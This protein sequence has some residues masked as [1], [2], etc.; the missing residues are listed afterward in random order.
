MQSFTLR[1]ANG[2]MS[3]KISKLQELQEA[4][5]RNTQEIVDSMVEMYKIKIDQVTKETY[6][7][8]PKA[9]TNN[10]KRAIKY[11]EESGNPKGCGT[12][13]GWTRAR[14]LANR[15]ALSRNT[16]ARMSSFNRHRQNKDV[17]YEEGCG[18]L[19]WDAWGG[20]EGID[21][22]QRKLKEIDNKE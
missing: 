20:T 4:I 13:V 11:K 3:K 6:S 2:S 12:A 16:I 7:D 18:G 21:W 17:P 8:Y 10:A 14:Q 1:K 22:A 9:A 19:M 5:E 15:E